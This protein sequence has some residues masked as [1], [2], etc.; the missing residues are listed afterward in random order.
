MADYKSSKEK[1]T[2]FQKLHQQLAE[3]I[4]STPAGEKLKSEPELAASL[5]VSRTT[6]RE[7]MRSFESQGLIRRRQGVGTF[8]IEHNQNIET[9]LETLES[10]ETQANRLG[11]DV[12]MGYLGIKRIPA[13]DEYAAKMGV[14]KDEEVIEI[15][16]V[17]WVSDHPVAYL[18]DVLLEGIL[19]EED[20]AQ[21][22]TGSVLDLL[23]R[24]KEHRLSYSKTFISACHADTYIAK[25]IQLQRSDVIQRFDAY[26]YEENGRMIDY[27]ISYFAPGFFKFHVN[28]KINV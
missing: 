11:L 22:F 9:G 19:S 6:L 4:E 3:I 17:I 12:K 5:Q 18:V 20:L 21:G 7:A 2:L 14:E 24:K 15:S 8:V 26:L 28:R 23:I 1:V 13:G 10:I 25:K 16:R 27:S